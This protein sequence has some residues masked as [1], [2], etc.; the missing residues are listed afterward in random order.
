MNTCCGTLDTAGGVVL[1]VA[2]ILYSFLG[3]A[4]ICDKYFCES[5]TMISAALNL[6][7]DVA[8]A[9]FMAA[10]SSAPELFTSLITVL[11]TG[12]SEGLGTITGSA[13]FNMM[14]I[15]GVTSI[16][17][18][19][20]DSARMPIWWFPLVRDCMFYIASIVLMFIF[21]LDSKICW[22]E[23]LILVCTYGAYVYA[24]KRN[25]ELAR[26]ASAIDH[27]RHQRKAAH[28]VP[29][30]QREGCDIEM[31]YGREPNMA[32]VQSS[33]VA[34]GSESASHGNKEANSDEP[35]DKEAVAALLRRATGGNLLLQ[36]AFRTVHGQKQVTSV[37]EVR[38]K[39][40]AARKK[41]F[42]TAV[43]VQRAT[44]LFLGK[45]GRK[46]SW[47]SK[48]EM[49]GGGVKRFPVAV[50]RLGDTVMGRGEDGSFL[51]R[52]TEALLLPLEKLFMYTVPDCS[53]ELYAT[54]YVGTFTMSILW[55]GLFSFVMCDFSIRVGCVLGIP[56]LLMGLVFIAAGTS[57]PDALS[58]VAV[59]K[60]GMGDMAVANVLGS[61]IFNIL[62][63]LGLPW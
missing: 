52:A 36:S 29:P 47:M 15:V 10:G 1:Y 56:G 60:S 13:V 51:D 40:R 39:T 35:F 30:A 28:D 21:M 58:S 45:L 46:A 57:V 20:N 25:E 17:S 23:A 14:V 9:T 11:I 62:L 63:G 32:A 5:L 38:A 4:V 24:M 3:L 2:V 27:K 43:Q 31:A 19:S 33:G 12:G 42:A 34:P 6:S 26:W 48:G 59:G 55:I 41:E 50:S 44:Q 7:D 54:W 53:K 61:N 16:A 8:G 18:C 22:W 37:A 49:S